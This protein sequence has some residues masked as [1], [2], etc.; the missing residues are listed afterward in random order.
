[1]LAVPGRHR[2]LTLLAIIMVA[3]ILLLA[4]QIKR[5][6]DVRLIRVWAV[7][8]VTPFQRAGNYVV[9]GVRNAWGGYVDLRH[10]RKENQEL[11]AENDRLK[12]RLSEADGRAA[13]AT[14]LAAL[15]EFRDAK[16]ELKSLP[17]RVIGSSAVASSRVILLN[18]GEKD[19]V[20]RD[21][22]VITPDGVVGKIIEAF[23]DTSQVLVLTD[24][25][26]G[27]GALLETSRTQGVVNGLGEAIL[28]LNYVA[29]FQA[30][31]VGERILT[32]GLDRVFPKDLP[33][34]TVLS[35]EQGNPFQKIRV[36]PAARLDRLEEVLILLAVPGALPAR[37]SK[38]TSPAGQPATK[39]P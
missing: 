5:E 38:G 4:I 10:I 1:M 2:S 3:Q 33:V 36:T 27:V 11:R 39:N 24:K 16:P 22:A 25:E 13:E 37:S 31:Q 26:S 35:V 32:S 30:V 9:G 28:A 21:M 23:P 15:L 19:G 6:Q 17:A 34:G 7:A 8:V 12:L 29:P 14:R 18:R 20:R